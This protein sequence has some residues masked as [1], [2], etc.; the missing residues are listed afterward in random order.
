MKIIAISDTHIGSGPFR[1]P[2]ALERELQNADLIIH[3]GDIVSFSAIETLEIYA[4]VKAVAGNCDIAADERIL[5]GKRL[6]TAGGAKIG[7]THILAASPREFR[8]EAIRLFDDRADIVVFGHTHVPYD[9][10]SRRPVLFNPGSLKSN[11]NGAGPSF[12][13]LEIENGAAKTREII[14]I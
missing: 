5:P 7:L 12:G 4:P 14:Y 13:I 8:R 9:D 11:R 2:A 10:D 3:A 1:F 6:F